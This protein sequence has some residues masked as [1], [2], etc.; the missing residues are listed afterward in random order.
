M[1]RTIATL[2]TTAV[3]AAGMTG[4]ADAAPWSGMS[5]VCAVKRTGVAS[6]KVDRANT[7]CAF[8]R[9]AAH[10]LTMNSVWRADRKGNYLYLRSPSSGHTLKLYVTRSNNHSYDLNNG[11]VFISIDMG[12]VS[13]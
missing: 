2:A 6:I 12:Y 7:S 9:K 1:K 13:G 5:K 8:G 4:I 11:V 3:A 10:R